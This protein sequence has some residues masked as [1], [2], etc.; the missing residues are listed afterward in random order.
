ML[1]EDIRIP[2]RTYEVVKVHKRTMAE[3]YTRLRKGDRVF[4]VI[5]IKGGLTTRG[6]KYTPNVEMYNAY[7]QRLL[8]TTTF[9]MFGRMAS[10]NIEFKEV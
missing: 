7:T 3:G 8:T 2:T 5:T 9:N 6:M 4:F 10:E 1:S